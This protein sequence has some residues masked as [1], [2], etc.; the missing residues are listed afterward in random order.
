MN[1]IRT[2]SK[3]HIA[4]IR[5]NGFSLARQHQGGDVTFT[6][7]SLAALTWANVWG[8]ATVSANDRAQLDGNTV[9]VNLTCAGNG[10]SSTYGT[11][12]VEG[13]NNCPAV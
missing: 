5:S 13:V 9:G 12:T 7:T 1:R 8:S 6:G 3:R 2:D 10:P 11:N 4:A